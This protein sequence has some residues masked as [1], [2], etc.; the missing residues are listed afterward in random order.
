MIRLFIGI[1]ELSFEYKYTNGAGEYEIY[2]TYQWYCENCK[3]WFSQYHV[4]CSFWPYC[5]YTVDVDDSELSESIKTAG[6]EAFAT[7]EHCYCSHCEE[8]DVYW[9]CW[10]ESL[11][12]DENE[13]NL[14]HYYCEICEEEGYNKSGAGTYCYTESHA[15]CNYCKERDETQSHR[16]CSVCGACYTE[17]HIHYYCKYCNSYNSTKHYYCL[18]CGKCV[19]S[20]SSHQNTSGQV[21]Y[22]ET[23]PDTRNRIHT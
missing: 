23:C 11:S 18:A 8:W 2:N 14:S 12:Y 10:D 7:H 9:E 16:Y 17:L 1:A 20:I 6:E 19:I 15:H 22:C 5:D 13:A 3:E 4:H 21:Y